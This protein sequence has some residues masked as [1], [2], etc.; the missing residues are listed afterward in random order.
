MAALAAAAAVEAEEPVLPQELL[1]CAPRSLDGDWLTCTRVAAARET[2]GIVGASSSSGCTGAS[3]GSAAAER[4]NLLAQGC[5]LE[6]APVT[7]FSS[8]TD[9]EREIGAKALAS[10]S[11]IVG[12]EAKYLAAGA[13]EDAA[14]AAVTPAV[15]WPWT[16]ATRSAFGPVSLPD[17][18]MGAGALQRLA[19]RFREQAFKE[20]EALR[21]PALSAI[22]QATQSAEYA[23]ATSADIIKFAINDIVVLNGL[24]RTELNGQR[25][26]VVPTTCSVEAERVGVQLESSGQRLA[27]KSA[28][29][30]LMHAASG[31]AI[32]G[33]GAASEA[34][35]ALTSPDDASAP[36]PDPLTVPTPLVNVWPYSVE[37]VSAGLRSDELHRTE[38]WHSFLAGDDRPV[39]GDDLPPPELYSSACDAPC[40]AGCY[41]SGGAR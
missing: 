36:S 8:F 30:E 38:L 22:E 13:L 21:A 14:L 27:V 32:G 29:L 6:E 12:A 4:H 25:A 16:P 20:A 40:I 34:A 3:G 35:A 33:A 17:K 28:N 24:S 5:V 31:S 26:R 2:D 19:E 10:A 7:S 37:K 39:G 23:A 18:A 15:I 1:R 41:L 11:V 9:M